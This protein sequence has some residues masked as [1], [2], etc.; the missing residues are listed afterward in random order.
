MLS[1]EKNNK[2]AQ[3]S[4]RTNRNTCYAFVTYGHYHGNLATDY[5]FL[6]SPV[7]YHVM[8]MVSLHNIQYTNIQQL[9]RE[10]N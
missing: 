10:R 4:K 1:N 6:I 9:N 7:T 5:S 8:I 3:Y 2:Y